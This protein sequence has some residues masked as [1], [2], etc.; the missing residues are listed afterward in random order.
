MSSKLSSS[1]L[2]VGSPEM[3]KVSKAKLEKLEKDSSKF[4]MER[5]DLEGKILGL[6][7]RL[8]EAEKRLSEAEKN[9]GE[10]LKKADALTSIFLEPDETTK[11]CMTVAMTLYA[12]HR[13]SAICETIVSEFLDE[14]FRSG[15]PEHERRVECV[16]IHC[17]VFVCERMLFCTNNEFVT[18]VSNIK[19]EHGTE[20]SHN[21]FTLVVEEYKKTETY[22]RSHPSSSD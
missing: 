14:F 1:S 13:S 22:K 9:A 17:V 18:V 2:S 19:K 21:T 6:T 3:V 7:N 5:L 16:C 10:A 15:A 11:L 20:I 12:M 4:F 8:T